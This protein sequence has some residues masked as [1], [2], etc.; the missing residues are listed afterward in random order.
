M[1][2]E[3][4]FHENKWL[5]SSKRVRGKF[6]LK[7]QPPKT[8][9]NWRSRTVSRRDS[10]AI[11]MTTDSNHPIRLENSLRKFPIIKGLRKSFA[12]GEIAFE[13]YAANRGKPHNQDN[14]DRTSWSE[15]FDISWRISFFT[16][17]SNCQVCF[18]ESFEIY[19]FY[20]QI[21]WTF[22]LRLNYFRI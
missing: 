11:T 17:H 13:S 19:L 6:F 7:P 22:Y 21:A 3:R 16:F 12:V 5:K 1:K 14:R 10:S 8:T 15:N 2:A 9:I 18:F 20:R 4:C